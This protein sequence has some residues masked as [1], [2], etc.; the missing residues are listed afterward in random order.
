MSQF[1]YKDFLDKSGDVRDFAI[2]LR[3]KING[4]VRFPMR[5]LLRKRMEKD[6]RF[7][8]VVEGKFYSGDCNLFSLCYSPEWYL[9][10]GKD[11][12]YCD[13]LAYVFLILSR[14]VNET[15]LVETWSKDIVNACI[16][17]GLA[18]RRLISRKKIIVPMVRVVPFND[19]LFITDLYNRSNQD[20]VYLSYDSLVFSELL[21]KYDLNGR[22]ICDIFCGSG[23]IGLVAARGYISKTRMSDCTVY[24]ID[25]NNRAVECSKANSVLSNINFIGYNKTYLEIQNLIAIADLVLFNPPFIFGPAAN[26]YIDSDGGNEGIQHTLNVFR[27]IDVFLKSGG[28]FAT[29]TQTPIVNGKDVLWEKLKAVVNLEINYLILDEFAPFPE[30]YDWYRSNGVERFRQVFIYG[31]RNGNALKRKS[32]ESGIYCFA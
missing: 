28:R 17:L 31:E 30:Y 7:E 25:I 5:R 29:I 11:K 18:E 23:I 32:K 9:E 27:L 16:E 15:E 2:L 6:Y 20:M 3:A 22:T 10:H 4:L 14:G 1:N 26:S 12:Y 24:G 19:D 21:V 8:S 13:Y